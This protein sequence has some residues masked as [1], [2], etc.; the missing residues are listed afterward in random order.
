LNKKPFAGNM[1]KNFI[2]S[3]Y[4]TWT[5]DIWF[6]GWNETSSFRVV[7]KLWYCMYYGV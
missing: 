4:W 2:A 1:K 7:L 3:N 6:M 5:H